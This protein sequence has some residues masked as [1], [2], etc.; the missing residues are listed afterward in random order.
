[1]LKAGRLPANQHE[2][3]VVTSM[4]ARYNTGCPA[5]FEVQIKKMNIFFSVSVPQILYGT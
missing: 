4:V 3:V 1:M 2:L 5:K